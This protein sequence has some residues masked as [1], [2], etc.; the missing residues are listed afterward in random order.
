MSTVTFFIQ[1]Q[2][3]SDDVIYF[4][5]V[6]GMERVYSVRYAPNDV[7][8][9]FTFTLQHRDLYDYVTNILTSLTTDVEPFERFQLTSRITPS[10]VY[11]IEDLYDS[12]TRTSI[13]ETVALA[14]TSHTR[15]RK[16]E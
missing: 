13:Y 8:G 3:Q 9:S 7:K 2:G 5:N 15:F 12:E 11:T 6:P 14:L 4:S 16:N 1:K 10:V